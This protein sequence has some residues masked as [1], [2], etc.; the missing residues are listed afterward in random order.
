MSGK[1]FKKEAMLYEPAGEGKV[2]CHLC[3][4]GCLIA[5]GNKGICTVRQ[6]QGGKLYTLVYGRTIARHVDPVEKKPLFHFHPGST[7]YSV[8]TPG[9][10][11]RC[12]WCQ[13]EEISQLPRLMQEIPGEDASPEAIVQA[14]LR[15]GCRSISYTYTEPTIFFEYSYDISRLARE[16]GLANVYVTNGYM[17]ARMLET[18][19]PYLDAANVDLKSFRDLTYRKHVG[20]RLQPVL[21]SLAEMKRLGIWLEVTTLVIPG[22]NDDPEELTDAARFVAQELGVETPW[23]ISRFFPCYRMTDVPPTPLATLR[24]AQ[25]I[26]REQGLR[27]VYL[28]NVAEGYDTFCAGCDQRLIRR[29]GFQVVENRVGPDGRCPDCGAV[30]AGVGVAG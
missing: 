2:R 19:H 13:N 26:G 11:F 9:C 12:A 30:L 8:A 28:G 7:S 10:N 6:N 17:T 1:S 23:H 15:Q 5:D 3:A 18:Y 25:Q 27:H 21:D 14:A 24:R 20:A 22:V 29:V 4:H 16:H